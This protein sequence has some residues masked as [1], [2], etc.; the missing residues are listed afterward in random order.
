MKVHSTKGEI[1]SIQ[2]LTKLQK[3]KL[4]AHDWRVFTDDSVTE[5]G[6]AARLAAKAEE[7]TSNSEIFYCGKSIPVFI[8]SFEIALYLAKNRVGIPYSF[9]A[10]HREKGEK[11]W[12]I[13]NENKWTPIQ[14]LVKEPSVASNGERLRGDAL[15]QKKRER[16][17]RKA[18]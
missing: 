14:K 16:L 18:I 1:V 3:L 17:A 7:Y 13:W 15:K 9:T 10:Y 5:K 6:I 4:E 2:T 11:S 12:H 8:V